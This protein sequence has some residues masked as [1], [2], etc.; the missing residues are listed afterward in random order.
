VA[1]LQT[2]KDRVVEATRLSAKK[3]GVTDITLEADRNDDGIDFLRVI[4]QL[5][6]RKEL[7]DKALEALL[8]T[9]EGAVGA[10][11]QRYPSVQF[12]DAA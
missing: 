2:I 12:V 5:K 10:I 7:N 11:D 4:V 1:D 3:V 8:E 6:P 9:I